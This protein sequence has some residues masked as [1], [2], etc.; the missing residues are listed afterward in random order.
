MAYERIRPLPEDFADAEASSV[1]ALTAAWVDQREGLAEGGA[2]TTFNERLVRRWAIETGI[3]EKLYTIDRG[4]TELLVTHGLDSALIEHGTTNI[5]AEELVTILKDHRDAAR[6]VIDYVAQGL[7]LTAHFIKS[8]H[9]LLCRHQDFTEAEDQF[10]HT[11]RVK[12][13]KGEWKTVA[14]NPKRPDGEM[15]EYCPPVLVNEEMETLLKLYAEMTKTGVA[16]VIRAAW[17]HH[18]FTQIHPFQDGNGRVARALTAMVFVAAEC[19]PIVVD[20]EIRDAYI[21]SLEKADGG[22]IR[23]LV[24]LLARL[25][26]KEIEQALSMSQDVLAERPEP[27]GALRAKLLEALRDKARD[28]R[29]AITAKRKEVLDKGKSVFDHVIMPLVEELAEELDLILS[30]ELPGSSATVER[31]GPDKR[32]F[33]KSQIV[34]IAQREGYFGD[35]ETAHEWVRLRLVRPGDSDDRNV[36]EIVI[37]M[38]SLG[39]HFTGV[40]V[41]TAYFATR[42]LDEENRSVA[43]DPHRLAERSL[44]FSYREEEANIS[45]RV[46]EW[47]DVVLDMGLAQLQA[48]M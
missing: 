34:S 29:Q 19:F 37:S 11:I 13:S 4:T 12:L 21:D 8:V 14:N 48:I 43:M 30:E 45:A 41:I 9:A 26:K 44:T 6:F 23:P 2:L 40:L 28:K 42:F 15:H 25:E 33:F 47:T 18:R 38:H 39:R 22:E 16:T 36:N 10:G 5:P 1:D 27:G 17:L 46:K 31:S 3:I 20:R 7:G 24:R 32:H 35:F